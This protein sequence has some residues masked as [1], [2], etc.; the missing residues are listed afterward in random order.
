MTALEQEVRQ[1][2]KNHHLLKRDYEEIGSIQLTCAF[3]RGLSPEDVRKN[4]ISIAELSDEDNDR[5]DEVFPIMK[6]IVEEND[7]TYTSQ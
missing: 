2:C 1:Y 5:F 6:A 3:I 4:T 7:N